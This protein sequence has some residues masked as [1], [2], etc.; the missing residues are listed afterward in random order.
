MC[1]HLPLTET[2]G[3]ML[4]FDN[5]PWAK[6]LARAVICLSVIAAI[7]EAYYLYSQEELHISEVAIIVLLLLTIIPPNVAIVMR[8]VGAEGAPMNSPSLHPR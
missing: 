2:G 7:A 6:P 8:K 5:R 1:R 4:P 3:Y